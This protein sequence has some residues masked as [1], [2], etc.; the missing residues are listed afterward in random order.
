MG[1]GQSD[2]SDVGA[3]RDAGDVGG[4]MERQVSDA[5]DRQAI[6]HAGYGH[7]TPGTGVSRD[8]DR[9]VVRSVSEL[10]L[11]CGRQYQE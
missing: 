3:N 8:G 1:E 5:G 2:A 10:C 11:H 7:R 4:E 9:A 6:C